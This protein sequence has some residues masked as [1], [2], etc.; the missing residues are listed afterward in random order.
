MTDGA[1]PSH[2]LLKNPDA[3]TA[4]KTAIPRD[5]MT[6][7]KTKKKERSF[8]FKKIIESADVRP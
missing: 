2:A 3:T 1:M 6:A 8:N 7:P 5:T 4:M